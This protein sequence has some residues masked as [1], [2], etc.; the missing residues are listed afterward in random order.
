MFRLVNYIQQFG[1]FQRNARLYLI[2]NALSGVTLGIILVLYNLYIVSLG[3]DTAF[4]GLLLFAGALGAGIAI[5]PAGLCIDR[6][7]GK[8]ILIWASALIG[9]AG[10]GQMLFRTSA[11]LFISTFFVGIGGAFVLVVNAP[12]L[13]ANSTPSER[14]HLF[15][16]AIVLTLATTVLGEVLGGT[17][18]LWLHSLP[19]LMAPLSTLYAGLLAAEPAARSYQLSLLLAGV[20]AA[21]SFIPL[22]LMSDDR[23]FHQSKPV[24]KDPIQLKFSLRPL[25]TSLLRLRKQPLR[26]LLSSPL[27]VL[28]MVQILIGTGAGLF[29]PYFN[30]YFVQHLKASPALFGIIDGAANTL[31]ALLTLLA[32]WMVARFGK[33]VTL[34]V[35]RLLSIP[36]MLGIGLAGSLPLAATLYPFRQGLMDMSQGILQLFSMEVVEPQQRGF[37]NSSYQAAYQVS[38]AS[39]ASLAGLIIA[40]MGYMP[41]FIGAAL[42]Y[43][44]ALLLLW[45]R[46]GRSDD[47]EQPD[48]PHAFPHAPS[49]S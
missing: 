29:L 3:Y 38:M 20:I 30:L 39:S 26:V 37:A 2:S 17:L 42:L 40:R 34:I 9:V 48:E 33:I 13:S 10:A 32:P 18:P 19:W 47:D 27:I 6:F 31:N 4:I 22:F 41:V 25:Q 24:V 46:F 11:P 7:G 16:L 15:S 8:A 12:F 44:L 5:F 36:L 21:P 35:P 49:L 28:I 1:R 14:P 23:P 43:A 45:S